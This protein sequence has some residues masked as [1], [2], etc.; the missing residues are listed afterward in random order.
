MAIP[1]DDIVASATMARSQLL[2]VGNF[3]LHQSLD[4]RQ[5]ATMQDH[6]Q[7]ST[8]PLRDDGGGLPGLTRHAHRMR[9]FAQT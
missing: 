3:T 9:E 4:G 2:N 7:V 5:P 1:D 8:A 6:D